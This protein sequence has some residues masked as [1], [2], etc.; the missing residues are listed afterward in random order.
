MEYKY[1][2][3]EI[4]QPSP[5]VVVLELADKSGQ[6]VFD[7]RPGQYV[8][9]SYANEKGRLERKHAFSLAS[10]PAEKDHIRLGIK[11]G[12]KFTQ[13][14][15]KLKK[16][17][18]V[19]VNGPF[20]GFIFDEKK[21]HDSVFLAGGIGITPFFSAMQYAADKGL[22][23]KMTLLY[24]NKTVEGTL[25]FREIRDLEKKNK[26]LRS[27]FSVTD[28]NVLPVLKGVVNRRLDA[29]MIQDFAG[30]VSGKTFFICGPASFM[31]SMK[32]HLLTLGAEQGQIEMEGFSMLTGA[33]FLVGTKNLAYAMGFSGALMMAS[34]Y[35]IANP[36]AAAPSVDSGK[37]DM[38]AP[39]LSDASVAEEQALAVPLSADEP[40]LLA[41]ATTTLPESASSS[42]AS[43]LL[44]F[45]GES[46][47]AT[48]G[49]PSATANTQPDAGK[50]AVQAPAA[51]TA[52]AKQ[53][54]SAAP[55]PKA[56]AANTASKPQA[57]APAPTTSASAPAH[58]TPAPTP[59]AKPAPT[60][61]AQPTSP[62]PA[63]TTSASAPAHTTPAPAASP[64]STPTSP[65]TA[66]ST[67]TT[68][69]PSPTT[70]ASAPASASTP[71]TTPAPTTNPA[72]TTA[73]QP[74]APAPTTS[75]SAPA[76]AISPS[77]PT[78]VSP[79]APTN[80][81]TTGRNRR[82]NEDD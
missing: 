70:S 16:G 7:F 76:P 56:A 59:A 33:G 20:G 47:A 75:A 9:I 61:S 79:T 27:L 57:A 45:A 43:A 4:H 37:L 18:Q 28:K 5:D 29:G 64:A 77:T 60:T 41:S 23:N 24:S 8:M 12:G 51:R 44:A 6:P 71:T 31:K 2:I 10:S 72:P 63:P 62:A 26:N 1:Q 38:A 68:T 81:A 73:T 22:P 25:F 34:F 82:S 69:V 65:T 3:R 17:S 40:P 46:E 52:P 50:A 15:L 55:V 67:P 14:L 49:S 53:P 32:Q 78:T 66:N 30:G 35:F 58:T 80:T 39:L 13:G 48:A 21:H 11:I 54:V 19:L 36:G 74:T 42:T